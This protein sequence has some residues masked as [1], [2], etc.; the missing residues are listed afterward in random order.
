M[1]RRDDRG[2]L[3]LR[4]FHFFTFR[5]FVF[6]PDCRASAI[7]TRDASRASAASIAIATVLARQTSSSNSRRR[8]SSARNSSNC[9]AIVS[10]F[11]NLARTFSDGS[12]MQHARFSGSNSI[13]SGSEQ[14][15]SVP[16]LPSDGLGYAKVA[17]PR[18]E[19]PRTPDGAQLD[20]RKTR[21]GVFDPRE[22]SAANR[23]RNREPFLS[24]PAEDR[25]CARHSSW[26]A[27]RGV[28]YRHESLTCRG[29]VKCPNVC[30]IK[31]SSRRASGSPGRLPSR[32][33]RL[34]N[35]PLTSGLGR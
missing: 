16:L 33:L 32:P 18:N 4:T 22:S 11:A 9:T 25:S 24:R 8:S 29:R 28:S 19:S 31:K 21:R 34:E 35:R 12:S 14:H 26:E 6:R 2:E 27:G 30:Q 13:L 10:A 7:S 20:T 3:D 17:R 15:N 1:V 23:G 5:G